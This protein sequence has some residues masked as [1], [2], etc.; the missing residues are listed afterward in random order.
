[1]GEM[2]NAGRNEYKERSIER[3]RAV[4]R[5]G[6]YNHDCACWVTQAIEEVYSDRCL[7]GT[8]HSKRLK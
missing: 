1:M 3:V 4:V 8:F 5:I 2:L 6:I 7:L